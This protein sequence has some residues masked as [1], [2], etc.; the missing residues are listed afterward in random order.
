MCKTILYI[1]LFCVSF[2]LK[3]QNNAPQGSSQPAAVSQYTDSIAKMRASATQGDPISQTILGFWYYYGFDTISQDYKQAVYWWDL[4]A[5]QKNADAIANLGYCY[6]RGHGVEADSAYA[7]KLFESA[8]SRGSRNVI[9]MHDELARQQ[10]SVFSALLLKDIYQRGLGTKKDSKKSEEYLA[11]AA[12]YGHEPSM[13]DYAMQLYNSKQYDLSAPWLKKL[14]DKGNAPC[15]LAYGLQ[16][17]EGKGVG[18]DKAK[19]VDYLKRAVDGGNN[20]AAVNLGRIY[21]EGDGVEKDGEKAFKYLKKSA[22]NDR[23]RRAPWLL[24]MCYK[25]AVGTKQDYSLAA[26]WMAESIDD[27]RE[28]RQRL[29]QFFGDDNEGTFTQYLRGLYRYHIDQSFS[30]AM[31]YFKIVEKGQVAEGTTMTALCL[32]DSRNPKASIKKAFRLF[33]KA[34]PDSPTACFYLSQ[35]Y[36]EGKGVTKDNVKAMEY[37]KLAAESDQPLALCALG[38]RYMTGNGIPKDIT[39]A[40]KLYLRAEQMHQLTPEAARNLAKCYELKVTALPDLNKAEERIKALN[41]IKN[42][43]RLNTLLA[44]VSFKKDAKQ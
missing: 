34:A 18:Q 29:D 7:F 10:K 2:Y 42:N 15:A 22:P 8:A 44:R 17:F 38:D 43:E 25:D 12:S 5:K 6:Q 27:S 35:L 19:A 14:A 32:S 20:S 4:A 11:M 39:M 36:A 40:A 21:Y 30:D 23:T 28:C 16:L 41:D 9:P 1:I 26:L 37:L 33:T 31:S 13:Y 24:A 3:A